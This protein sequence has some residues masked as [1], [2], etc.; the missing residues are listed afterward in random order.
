M[1][2]PVGPADHLPVPSWASVA[3]G[4]SKIGPRP[5]IQLPVLSGV[6]NT[7]VWKSFRPVVAFGLG[8]YSIDSN[9][10]MMMFHAEPTGIGIVGS[11]LALSP[12]LLSGP[13][14][15][16]VTDWNGILM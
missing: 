1:M 12:V 14:R 7:D 16:P 10:W 3:V 5:Q 8:R 2:A 15:N 6:R 4:I 9:G 13:T 11:M